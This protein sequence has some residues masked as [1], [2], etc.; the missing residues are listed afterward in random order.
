MDFYDR[1]GK[2]ITFSDKPLNARELRRLKHHI[3]T[4]FKHT[5]FGPGFM[6]K[7]NQRI[8]EEKNVD[9]S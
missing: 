2:P 9:N 1:K 4:D 5:N 8:A 7:L 6:R 3:L